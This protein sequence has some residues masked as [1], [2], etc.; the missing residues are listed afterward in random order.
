M[1]RHVTVASVSAMEAHQH[2]RDALLD[3]ASHMIWRA[4]Q[5]GADIVS[6][7]ESY[8]H[9][10]TDA[11]RPDRAE[12]LSGPT[13]ARVGEEARQHQLHVIMSMYTLEDG[14]AY[15]SAVLVAPSG[16]VAG[17]YHKMFP[18][19]GEIEDGLSPGVDAPVFQTSFGRVAMAICFDLNFPE[20]M[21]GLGDAG[22][23]VV[24]FSS[25]Y[26]GGLQL[27]AWAW[28]LGCYMVSAIR[29]ELGQIVDMSGEILAESTY[30]GLIAKRIN[31]DRRLLHMD[32][33]WEKMD[34]MLRKY[35]P[36]V[37]FQYFTREGCYTIASER[38]D[39]TVDDLIRE[40][41]LEERTDYFNRS[42]EVR[43]KALG[44]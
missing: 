39:L 32:A 2:S 12:P 29:G 10:A 25:A 38:G 17:V 4:K 24:F 6:F 16:E 30:E 36:G 22:A 1:A 31:L 40:F 11:P 19:I 43:R 41:D 14:H 28:E 33:N 7:P 35:G 9:L 37:S 20:I 34:E 23:E 21:R 15:N 26:R 42:R 44:L 18:T 5:F 13:L 27:R 3:H 8:A